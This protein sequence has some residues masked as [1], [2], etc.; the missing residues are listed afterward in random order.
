MSGK[1]SY[2][3]CFHDLDMGLQTHVYAPLGLNIRGK[4]TLGGSLPGEPVAPVEIGLGIPLQGLYLREDVDMRCNIMMTSFVKK[5]LKKAHA[6]LVGRL[7]IKS[8]IVD[9][10]KHN[11]QINNLG[12]IGARDPESQASTEYLPASDYDSQTLAESLTADSRFSDAYTALSPPPHSNSF[13]RDDR[14]GSRGGD[15][16][17]DSLYPKALSIR[18]SSPSWN[19]SINENQNGWASHQDSAL[20]NQ[21]VSWQNLTTARSSSSI[22]Q[23]NSTSQNQGMRPQLPQYNPAKYAQYQRQEE[24]PDLRNRLPQSGYAGLPSYGAVELE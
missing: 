7:L 5:T 14:L 17:D 20:P 4:W 22:H 6:E 1:V 24:R 10:S 21:R 13:R 8:Q 16:K 23:G 2:N 12:N 15:E 18:S 11:E 3:A 19:G 9:A